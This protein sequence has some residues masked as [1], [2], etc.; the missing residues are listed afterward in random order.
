MYPKHEGVETTEEAREDTNEIMQCNKKCCS[1][2]ANVSSHRNAITS[3]SKMTRACKRR[4]DPS[5][6][7]CK[8]QIKTTAVKHQSRQT[9]SHY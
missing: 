3:S 5:R 8:A 6:I 1:S 9:Q 7:L 2:A 4:K